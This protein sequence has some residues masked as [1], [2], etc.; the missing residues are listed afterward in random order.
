[1]AGTCLQVNG[2]RPTSCF[3]VESDDHSVGLFFFG[4][5]RFVS[6][7]FQQIRQ[8]KLFLIYWLCPAAN[9]AIA[10]AWW[11]KLRVCT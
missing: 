10:S 11:K 4:F 2:Q 8:A 1:M 5:V 7:G 6:N 9:I 3:Y